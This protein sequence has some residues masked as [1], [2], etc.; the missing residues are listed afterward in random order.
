MPERYKFSFSFT[1]LQISTDQ[2]GRLIDYERGDSK[3]MMVNQIDE[4]LSIAA[5]L[6]D[7]KAEFVI[8][9]DITLDRRSGLIWTGDTGFN[10]GK[11]IPGQIKNSEA[12]ALFVCTAGRRISEYTRKLMS[13]NNYLAGY[14]LDLI[15]SEVADGAA[16][17][18]QEELRKLAGA[19]DQKITNRY[20]PG[21]CGWHVSEQ[22]LLFRLIP[23]NYCGV[24]LNSSSLMEP[25]KSVSGIIGIGKNVSFNQYT[26]NLCDQKNCIY[27]NFI[28]K[29]AG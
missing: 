18:M 6:C 8:Y 15:G 20:S 5:E 21:Y 4:M 10:T 3:E 29:P 19:R 12:I 17:L 26:C 28:K 13:E 14:I 25:V 27:R 9:D 2:V 24:K 23:D 11:I 1:D 7:I 16:D 22:Q